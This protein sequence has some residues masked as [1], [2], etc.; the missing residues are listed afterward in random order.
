LKTILKP[1]NNNIQSRSRNKTMSWFD[2]KTISDW[3][4][5]KVYLSMEA[6]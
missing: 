6:E 5:G 2:K 4:T 1:E 3:E